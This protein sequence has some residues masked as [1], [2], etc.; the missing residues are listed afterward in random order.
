M[1]MMMINIDSNV[2]GCNG[3][4]DDYEDD[5]NSNDNKASV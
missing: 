4:D 2:H 5:C 1:M 3:D